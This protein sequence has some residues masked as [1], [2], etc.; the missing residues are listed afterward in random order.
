M[1]E[2][3]RIVVEVIFALPDGVFGATV[4]LS[5]GA[6]VADAI[7]LSGLTGAVSQAGAIPL[8]AGIFG[9]RVPLSA[10]PQDGDRIEIYRPLVAD[11]KQLRV[12]RAR[13]ATKAGR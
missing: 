3:A 7:K 8:V 6:T 2:P 10:Q 11:P 13:G 4:N 1:D 5:A 9:R 12:T